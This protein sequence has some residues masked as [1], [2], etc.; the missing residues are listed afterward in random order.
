MEDKMNNFFSNLKNE[1]RQH[2]NNRPIWTNE[3]EKLRFES[4]KDHLELKI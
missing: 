4:D 1:T 3:V 2:F